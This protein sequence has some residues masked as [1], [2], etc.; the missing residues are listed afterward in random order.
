MGSW[1]KKETRSKELEYRERIVSYSI[2]ERV[3]SHLETEYDGNLDSSEQNRKN[4]KNNR[5]F[6][7]APSL[8]EFCRREFCRDCW[9]LIVGFGRF[10]PMGKEK[11]VRKVKRGKAWAWKK[12]NRKSRTTKSGD[13]AVFRT[14]V[15]FLHSHVHRTWLGSKWWDSTRSISEVAPEERRLDWRECY[16]FRAGDLLEPRAA[17]LKA[18]VLRWEKEVSK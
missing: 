3:F 16:A 7:K 15:P 12:W 10:S 8:R 2:S 11:D 17:S 18:E 5:T 6:P 1:E 9:C 4:R 13:L 14:S